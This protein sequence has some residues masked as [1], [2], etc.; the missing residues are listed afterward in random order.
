LQ[1]NGQKYFEESMKF[2]R[3][4]T[5]FCI[6]FMLMLLL[7]A[8]RLVAQ[9]TYHYVRP[10][11][12]Q[13]L[14]PHDVLVYQLRH[15][16]LGRIAQSPTPESATS[17]AQ[18]AKQ[19]RAQF[20]QRIFHGWPQQWI[21]ATPKF[22][23]VG[24]IETGKGY[25]IH[26]FRY[27]VV[28]GYYAAALLYE[29]EKLTGRVPGILNVLGHDLIVGKSADYMQKI[30]IN[31]A[32]QQIMALS[33]EFIDTG[34]SN[35][36]GNDHSFGAQLNLV[37]LQD[38]GLFY[39]AMRKG[40]D[41]LASHQNVD[42]SRLG[43][44]GLSGGG[45]QTIMLSGL[46]E[47]VAAAVPVA[48]YSSIQ[49]RIEELE[50]LTSI[51]DIEQVSPDVF[52]GY[53]YTHLTAL[54]A[55]RPTLLI[56]N[57]NDDCCFRAALSKSL[58]FDA[59]APIFKLYGKEDALRWYVNENPGTHNYQ[60]DNREQ[61]YRFFGKYLQTP[62]QNK[63]IGSHDE[64]RTYEDLAVDL[65]PE[66]L[67]LLS[68]AQKTASGFHRL[69]VPPVG[70]SRDE[71]STQKREELRRVLH[72]KPTPLARAWQL[73]TGHRDGVDSLSY[74]FEMKDGLSL[75]G[76]L[77][78][79]TDTDSSA[80]ATLVLDDR[81]RGM[82]SAEVAARVDRGEQVLAA[83]LL[84]TDEKAMTKQP[85]GVGTVGST[86]GSL[87][88]YAQVFDTVGDRA[89]GIEVAEVIELAAWLRA[90][91]RQQT[92]R[93]ESRG[94]RSQTVALLAVAL[95]PGLFSEFL[96][97]KGMTSFGYLLD[98]PVSSDD[99]ADL[100]CLDLYKDFNIDE[101]EAMCGAVRVSRRDSLELK[102]ATK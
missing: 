27:E 38:D 78:K 29:P 74:L 62:L 22:E 98:L 24:V 69:K 76:V 43:V 7:S 75:S 82:T 47:R 100:F 96:A 95:D 5:M 39:L 97:R 55:P 6:L 19:I 50:E 33:L 35:R 66:N 20:L 28:P 8:P 3:G 4:S 11:L 9:F 15:Y 16:L 92:I 70:A 56:Y 14:L 13:P 46:D 18:D 32:K 87:A 73:D 88:V 45:W 71:W 77:L 59:I 79:G 90:R 41:Y 84:F 81:G 85:D 1:F 101:L 63:E 60:L 34:E 67:T 86:L 49:Q 51:G 17:W 53:D 68:L 57:V 36:L 80:P 37:G 83:N 64:I 54:R 40:L 23:E 12:E 99:A 72:Y 102:A 26:K 89:L 42:P 25:R 52:D 21:N 10:P 61:A 2:S 58:V 93:I 65:M 31:F 30:C 48:G 91:A 44:T 94:I